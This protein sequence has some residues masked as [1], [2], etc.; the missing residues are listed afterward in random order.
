[1]PVQ[2][3]L[4]LK[5][6]FMVLLCLFANT[7]KS[8]GVLGNFKKKIE[9]KVTK[10]VDGVLDPKKKPVKKND[11][12]EPEDT[13]GSNKTEAAD[14][15]T[16]APK[17]T[18]AKSY[19][20]R[21]TQTQPP[22]PNRPVRLDIGGHYTG[23][24]FNE[25]KTKGF[26]MEVDID[27]RS[28][29]PAGTSKLTIDN[30]TVEFDMTIPAPGYERDGSFGKISLFD[31]TIISQDAPGV[32][33][34]KFYQ[35]D[36]V[37]YW[38]D[39]LVISGSWYSVGQVSFKNKEL[40]PDSSD[41]CHPG[42]F[43]I[44]KA[45][46]YSNY[47]FA[48]QRSATGCI[49]GDCQTGY[50]TQL[51]YNAKY[52]GNFKN[53]KREGQ[54][55]MEY[56]KGTYKGNKYE[57]HFSNDD[58]NGF[59]KMTFAPNISGRAYYEGNYVNSMRQGQGKMVSNEGVVYAGNFSRDQFWGLGKRIYKGI[60]NLN[61]WR[62]FSVSDVQALPFNVLKTHQDTMF[63]KLKKCDCLE[64][65]NF[66]ILGWAYNNVNY[67]VINTYTGRKVGEK[68]ESELGATSLEVDGYINNTDHDIYIRCYRKRSYKDRDATEYVDDS[69]IVA[70][71]QKIMTNY[72]VQPQPGEFY[73]V[74]FA[75]TFVY[76]GQYCDKSAP[77]CKKAVAKPR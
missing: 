55:K 8:Q 38:D 13:E 30:T 7:V 22:P 2:F 24:F 26:P 70:P 43:R 57:G 41:N 37:E 61:Y 65:K 32:W 71:G 59:G 73:Y 66:S 16:G 49:S 15:S 36:N 50:G 47:S 23:L 60:S 68:T 18:P 46:N 31:K 76:L 53:G 54:G 12:N 11:P 4:P 27:T 35:A 77:D 45:A 58:F 19:K 29:Y 72:R 1:M 40:V 39:S 9:K 14:D 69:Y 21:R 64:K 5:T 62:Y 75:D 17:T 6:A 56:T 33:C 74:Y 51:T 25:D 42:S 44:T 48:V 20:E 52:E 28:R 34:K 3:K 63:A 10:A 67:D